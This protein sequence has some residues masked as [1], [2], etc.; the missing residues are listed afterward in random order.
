MVVIE[1]SGLSAMTFAWPGRYTT[2]TK[3]KCCN[4]WMALPTL[5]TEHPTCLE[6]PD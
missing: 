6:I 3:S 4:A 2:F 1:L 5:D